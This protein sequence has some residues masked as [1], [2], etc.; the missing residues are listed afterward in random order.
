MAR[1][2]VMLSAIMK[3]RSPE[4]NASRDLGKKQHERR[5]EGNHGAPYG[6]KAKQQRNDAEHKRFEKALDEY[7]SFHGRAATNA[8]RREAQ[9]CWDKLDSQT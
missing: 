3:A 4:R 1:R 5:H 8:E 9:K 6:I 2:T 7:N